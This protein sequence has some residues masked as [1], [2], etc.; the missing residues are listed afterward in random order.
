MEGFLNISVLE[1]LLANVVS[2]SGQLRVIPQLRFPCGGFISGFIFGGKRS[3]ATAESENLRVGLWRCAT[4]SALNKVDCVRT[5][6]ISISSEQLVPMTGS[7]NVYEITTQLTV[8]SAQTLA[9]GIEQGA[10][11]N[12]DVT[13]YYQQ[14]N[15]TNNYFAQYVSSQSGSDSVSLSNSMQMD[16]PLLYPKYCK[17]MVMNI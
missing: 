8:A 3:I 7:P 17:C 6:V 12:S 4:P 15:G 10:A 1:T 13:L 9:L 11:A 16:Q 14:D 5:T 2:Y